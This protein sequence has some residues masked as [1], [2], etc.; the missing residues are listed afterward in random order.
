M[1]VDIYFRTA[2]RLPSGA[3]IFEG[4]AM[5]RET[6]LRALALATLPEKSREL[7]DRLE[8][9]AGKEIIFAPYL[10]ASKPD[11]PNPDA[12]S[13]EVT[14]AGAT[15]RLREAAPIPPQGITHELLHLERWWLEGM[16]QLYPARPEARQNCELMENALEHL[17]IV[18]REAEYRIRALRLLE[19]HLWE[20]MVKEP[21]PPTMPAEI[22]R[23]KC[24]M[25]W[26]ATGYITDESVI[27]LIETAVRAEGHYEE[28]VKFKRRMNDLLSSKQQ[29][30]A[31]LARFM[32]IPEG[33]V[34]LRYYNVAAGTYRDE[35]V[36]AQF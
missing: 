21:F 31:C 32:N 2:L 4:D 9:H 8:A 5:D 36:M 34:V 28:A 14:P 19:R 23:T 18:P 25:G 35:R 12:P 26:L 17:V 1:R 6:G 22:I 33:L 20:K 30:V 15:I 11:E 13:C 10:T 7:L 24:L 27:A 29:T 16:P 3:N